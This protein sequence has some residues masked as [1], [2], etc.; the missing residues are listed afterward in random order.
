MVHLA[1]IKKIQMKYCSFSR[2]QLQGQESRERWIW[3]NSGPVIHTSTDR[4]QPGSLNYACPLSLTPNISLSRACTKFKRG[5]PTVAVWRD[6]HKKQGE[7]GVG[8]YKI[9]KGGE[10]LKRR[11]KVHG[12]CVI[13]K[14]LHNKTLQ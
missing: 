9:I 7:L 11:N 14:C 2:G 5:T 3:E 8:Q 13:A 4:L 6:S 1:S 10:E 12:E